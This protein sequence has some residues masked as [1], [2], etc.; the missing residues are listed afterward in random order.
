MADPSGR[1]ARYHTAVSDVLSTLANATTALAD[2]QRRLDLEFR[3]A[4]PDHVSTLSSL[5]SAPLNQPLLPAAGLTGSAAAVAGEPGEAGGAWCSP[6]LNP[7][8]SP[9]R[10]NAVSPWFCATDPAVA[11]LSA[12]ELIDKMQT[13]LTARRVATRRLLA[14]SGLPPVPEADAAAH[15]SLNE[16]IDEWTAHVMP[17]KGEDRVEDTNQILFSTMV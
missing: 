2:V 13:S 5:P 14:A 15:N 17:I 12:Q 10:G 3:A 11:S 16:V 1:P 4:Y 6:F 9:I 8:P 7:N